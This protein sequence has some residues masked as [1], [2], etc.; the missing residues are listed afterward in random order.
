MIN[1]EECDLKNN[2]LVRQDIKPLILIYTYSYIIFILFFR[3]SS[4]MVTVPPLVLE[5]WVYSGFFSK[6]TY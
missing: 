1:E 4:V 5:M 2:P 6:S 3:Q